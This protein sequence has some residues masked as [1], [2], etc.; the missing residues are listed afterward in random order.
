MTD[1]PTKTKKPRN[2]LPKVR[3]R[4]THCTPELIAKIAGAIE[5]GFAR[6]NAMLGLGVAPASITE[7]I[8]K[9]RAGI[10]PYSDLVVAIEEAKGKSHNRV[11]KQLAKAISKG[12]PQ[13][14]RIKN[15]IISITC[16]F[17]IAELAQA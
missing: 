14:Y 13:G 1:T 7:W 15:V 2:K 12:A 8:F 11:E 4:P 6:D 16:E 5:A 9:G 17:A 3:T 10:P